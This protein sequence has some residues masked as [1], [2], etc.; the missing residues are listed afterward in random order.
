MTDRPELLVPITTPFDSRDRVDA[1]ALAENVTRLLE[2]G[3]DGVVV[4]GSTGEAAL[5]DAEEYATAVRAA[6]AATPVGRRLVA[7][8]GTESTRSTVATTK[9]AADLGVDA[10]MVRPP[11]YY[12]AGLSDAAL[13]AH[14]QHVADA[15]PV[16][17][18]LYNIPKYTPVTLTSEVVG[19]LARHD[20]VTG[21]KDSGGNMERFAA[22]RAAG[23]DL[24]LYVGS[25]GHVVDAMALGADGGILAAACFVP[26]AIRR[27]VDLATGGPPEAARALA[28]RLRGA[29]RDIV[30]VAGIPGIKYAMDQVGFRGGAPR[31]PLE[32]LDR[33]ARERVDWA[34]AAARADALTAP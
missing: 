30:G 3:V 33:V 2:L 17:V 11:C 32:P 29:A 5:L 25:L 9:V 24:T 1:D 18:L 15:S 13:V 20:R 4:A 7:G 34:L 16:P 10:V 26:E 14:Y 23:P 22:F 6:R 27:L 21:L 31:R 8:A 12:G 19:T 28:E